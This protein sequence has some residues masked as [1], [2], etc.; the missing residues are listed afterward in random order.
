[1]TKKAQRSKAPTSV[2]APIVAIMEAKLELAQSHAAKP[3]ALAS[4]APELDEAP[5]APQRDTHPGADL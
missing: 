5:H 1:M 3:D 2:S 4:S